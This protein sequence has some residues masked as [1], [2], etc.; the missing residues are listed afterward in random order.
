MSNTLAP[1]P[2]LRP[3][4]EDEAI[5]FKG[6]EVHI[7]QII[8]QLEEKKIVV[9]TGASGDGKSSLIYAGVIPQAR[10]G[11]FKS[12][13]SNW[14]VADFR[15]ERNPLGN[16]ADSLAH[17]LQL[18]PEY[19]KKELS[20]GFASLINLFKQ[21]DYYINENNAEWKNADD[22]TRKLRRL[23]SANL[24]ILADQFEEIFTNSENYTNGRPSNASYVVVNTLLETARIAQRE[25]IP[26][27][28]I[29]TM[30]SDYI[31]QCV[32][33]KNLPEILAASNFFVPRLKR[34]ELTQ[35]IEEPAK[36]AGG[37]VSRRLV[38]L[39]INNLQEGFDR[40][41]V[42]QH[43][44]NQLWK[45][46]DYGKTQI[47]LIHLAK[48]AGI[49][50]ALLPD[51]DKEEFDRWFVDLE[52]YKKPYYDTP[53][54][55]NVLNTH[56]NVLYVSAYEYM[57]MHFGWASKT[58][59]P[60][61]SLQVIKTSF[62]SLTKIDA[63]R[64]VRNRMTLIEIYQIINNPKIAI[65]DISAIMTVFRLPES[66]FVRPFVNP[67]DLSTEY[68]SATST[69]DITHEALIRNW[70][71]LQ[72]W[73]EEEINNVSVL[74]D[75]KVQLNRWL[76]HN[77]SNDFLLSLGPLTVFGE[78]YD[79]ANPNKY[80]LAKYNTNDLSHVEK[81][82]QS[83]RLAEDI[84]EYLR[85]SK[86][87]L[88]LQERQKKQ[89]RLLLMISS[90]LI[91]I[92]LSILTYWANSERKEAEQQSVLAQEQ[93]ALAEQEKNNA[94]AANQVAEHERQIAK[95]NAEKAIYAKMLSDS[96]R[97]DAERNRLKAETNF[98]IAQE[99]TMLASLQAEKA[100]LEKLKS[101][102]LRVIA[103]EQKRIALMASDSANKLSYLSLAQTL[104]FKSHSVFEDNDLNLLLAL[105]AYTFN[106]DHGGRISD[107][108][109]YNALRKAYSLVS[110]EGIINLPIDFPLSA[111][112]TTSNE[113]LVVY[114]SGIVQKLSL[115]DGKVSVLQQWKSLELLNSAFF[116]DKDHLLYSTH[117]KKLILFTLSSNNKR[118]LKITPNYA[119]AAFIANGS[120][121]IGGRNSTLSEFSLSDNS[122]DPVR[123]IEFDSRITDMV[124]VKN[125]ATLFLGLYNGQLFKLPFSSFI[126]EKI[127][128]NFYRVTAMAYHTQTD[129]IV[130]GYSNGYIRTFD[131]KG[132]MGS[133]FL[134]GKNAAELMCINP[135]GEKLAVGFSN[136]LVKVYN[137]NALY[138]TPLTINDMKQKIIMLDFVTPDQIFAL[139]WDRS[140]R[141]WNISSA[142]Y[143]ELIKQKL[144]RNMSDIEWSTYVG[145]NVPYHAIK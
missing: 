5:Y 92:L 94:V 45:L 40:L 22:R 3:F 65:E 144:N 83:A 100:R 104:A 17:K 107:P 10:A 62:Q 136:N 85:V 2:G 93:R 8:K 14:L 132:N 56:A 20:F 75:F 58:I 4:T 39:L 26:V 49:S 142:V 96:A 102:S 46:A 130:V 67:D 6:R 57:V 139:G 99:Q 114:T 7:K 87:F 16:L 108:V 129:M 91:I 82:E 27:Y 12:K 109:I 137:F 78:W 88:A 44:L 89:R 11:F 48:L 1:Y 141:K 19:T 80:W 43:A 133:E 51:A 21:S 122:S 97:A 143:A 128:S 63:G 120:V 61:E 70:K 68:I 101:D 53:N 135:S 123:E 79:R 134:S 9:V 124:F 95:E 60:F 127:F 116:L 50:P 64:A 118:E 34:E 110:N 105:H 115:I 36:L 47:D 119:R 25:G 42:L 71:L 23:K 113:Y 55:D 15:P 111:F 106:K 112:E 24:L 103:E 28:V 52:E 125:S 33:F 29:L 37:S 86:S 73:N 18:N 121:W 41:P 81:I 31:S 131:A 38:E 126:P 59:S 72:D 76:S 138:E 66:T 69:L 74:S 90:L 32:A 77:K 117:S 145:K 54:V 35:V 84:E 13:Y 98:R 30:R 140:I